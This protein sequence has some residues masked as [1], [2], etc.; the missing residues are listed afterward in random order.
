MYIATQL[1]IKIK[2]IQH[3]FIK[4]SFLWGEHNRTQIKRNNLAT[5]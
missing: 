2:S 5:R 4:Q 3:S 1:N